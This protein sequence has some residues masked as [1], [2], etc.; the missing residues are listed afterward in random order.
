MVIWAIAEYHNAGGWPSDGFSQSSGTAHVWNI[1]IIYPIL[2]LAVLLGIDGWKTF[3]R[4]PISEHEV[5]RE[6]E[7]LSGE[8]R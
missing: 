5:Q 6:M 1:W 7:R 8:L 4:R 2:V 3:G